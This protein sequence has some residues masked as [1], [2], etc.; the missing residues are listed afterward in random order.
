VVADGLGDAFINGVWVHDIGS[1]GGRFKRMILR[2][3]KMLLVARRLNARVYHFH[4]PEILLIALFL[5]GG[6]A[7]VVY[8]SHEDMPRSLLSRDWIP[9]W[10]KPVL[11]SA[12]EYFENF[13]ARRLSGVIGATPYIADRFSRIN[14]MTEAINNYPLESEIGGMLGAYNCTRTVCYLGAISRVRGIFEMVHALEYVDVKLIL[15]GAFED[16]NIERDVRALP[17]WN[18][19]DYRGTI[20]RSEVSKI[21]TESSAGLVLYHSEPNH[22]NAQPNKMFE[23]MSVG[24]PVIASN[25]LLWREIIEGN[26]CGICVDPLNPKAIG[27]AIQYLMDNPHKAEQMGKN[28]RKAVEQKYNWL[29]EEKKLLALYKDLLK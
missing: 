11:S 5:F 6:G 18:K 23:Y 20:S 13:V 14:S 19:V 1:P 21:M 9:G 7:A 27:D 24:L 28:G 12:F 16:A 2:P 8:D 29:I 3:W 25:F 22:I 4:D 17:G 15:A 26:R 10:I